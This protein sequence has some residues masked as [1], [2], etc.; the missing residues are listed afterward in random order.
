[1]HRQ[2]VGRAKEKKVAR[3]RT[4]DLWCW[5]GIL[6]AG[7]LVFLRLLISYSDACLCLLREQSRGRP[8]A[9]DA[10]AA[11]PT[12]GGYVRLGS[13]WVFVRASSSASRCVTNKTKSVSRTL[14][15]VSERACCEHAVQQGHIRFA[16]CCL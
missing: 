15:Q 2:R 10:L 13:T 11:H 6:C 3:K 4:C 1:M 5:S 14:L 12:G 7:A 16:L 8:G 9:D